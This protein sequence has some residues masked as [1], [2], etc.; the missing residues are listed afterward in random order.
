[1]RPGLEN[2]SAVRMMKCGIRILLDQQYRRA[3]LPDPFDRFKDRVN[4]QRG[5][6][7][8]GFIEQRSRGFDISARA[9]ASIC[10]SPPESVPAF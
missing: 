6:S 4:Y 5:E 3:F 9:I 1:M 7:E 10:C 2:V 8:R